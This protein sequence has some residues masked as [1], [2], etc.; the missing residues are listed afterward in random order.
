MA[1]F[2]GRKNMEEKTWKKK[3]R[4]LDKK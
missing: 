1:G 4:G 2:L 3:H